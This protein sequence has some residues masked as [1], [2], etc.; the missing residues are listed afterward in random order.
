MHGAPAA[1]SPPVDLSGE[2]QPATAET[3]AQ[4]TTENV[5]CLE[6]RGWAMAAASDEPG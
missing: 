2:A 1:Q 6:I 4:A 5:Q 3:M